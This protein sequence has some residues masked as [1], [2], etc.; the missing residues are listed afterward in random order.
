MFIVHGEHCYLCNV[1]LPFLDMQVDHIVPESLVTRPEEL[2]EALRSF[3]L[4]AAFDVNSYENWLPACGSCNNA[5]QSIVVRSSPIFQVHLE[6]AARKANACR[7]ME[8]NSTRRADVAKA[9]NT[10]ERASD[11]GSLA[12]SDR[13]ALEALL[14][15]AEPFRDRT[16]SAAP[17]KLTVNYEAAHRIVHVDDDQLH[18]T[19]V[20]AQGR[21]YRIGL[22][23]AIPD[24]S[25][26]G[27]QVGILR[28]VEKNLFVDCVWDHMDGENWTVLARRRDGTVVELSRDHRRSMAIGYAFLRIPSDTTDNIQVKS[29]EDGRVL[30]VTLSQQPEL[31]YCF[32]ERRVSGSVQRCPLG[33]M[34]LTEAVACAADFKE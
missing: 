6:R 29:S 7:K 25:D 27:T 4:P 28:M 18:A 21:T 12:P 19:C 5:K 26:R 33:Q 34:T 22:K 11:E 30:E 9:L 13:G 24:I 10:I 14:R 8:A 15:T 16:R 3:G 2:A 31:P 17:M 32:L 23:G 20:D 1:P